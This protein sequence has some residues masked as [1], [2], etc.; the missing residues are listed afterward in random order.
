MKSLSVI[1][2]IKKCFFR[3]KQI[4]ENVSR[5]FFEL[6]GIYYEYKV[7]REQKPFVF[8]DWLGYKYWLY[9]GDRIRFNFGRKAV[10]DSKG[11]IRYLLEN[12]S[13]GDVCID[14]GAAIGAI[15]I[16]LW[17]KVG[18]AGTVL[19]IEADPGKIDKITANLKLNKF[20]VNNVF[21]IAISDTDSIKELRCFPEAPGWNTFGNPPFA[22]NY[23]SFTINVH[24]T[25]FGTLLDLQEI[26]KVDYV[27]IDTEGSEISILE[28]MKTLLKHKKVR[29]IIFEVNYLML[30]GMNNSINELFDLWKLFDYELW[31]IQDDGTLLSI[32]NGW[33]DNL[34][35]DCVAIARG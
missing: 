3:I 12:V 10:L 30:E 18:K 13:E 24:A 8:I 9:P 29:Q 11:V 31:R 34:I 35:G 23:E 28:G 27:K 15:S 21:N 7:Y 1:E 4:R 19:S 6:P 2:L 25:S 16:P 22:K 32:E 17:S 14:I 20:P 5:L 26:T 33:P